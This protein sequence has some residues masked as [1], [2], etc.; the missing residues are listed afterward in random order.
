VTF[1]GLLEELGQSEE[2]AT[3]QRIA[4]QLKL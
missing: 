1:R 3:Q 2:L 4:E